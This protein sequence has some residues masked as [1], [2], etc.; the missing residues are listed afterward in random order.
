MRPEAVSNLP[1]FEE[2]LEKWQAALSGE[3]T[4]SSFGIKVAGLSDVTKQIL[5]ESVG[6]AFYGVGQTDRS[7]AIL[8]HRTRDDKVA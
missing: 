4:S 5:W 3:D 7:L 2:L 6:M 1:E 8:R